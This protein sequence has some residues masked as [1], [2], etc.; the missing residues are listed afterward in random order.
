[1]TTRR[2][3]DEALEDVKAHRLPGGV[4]RGQRRPL[5]RR[6]LRAGGDARSATGRRSRRSDRDRGAPRSRSPTAASR[7]AS[8][9]RA[10]RRTGTATG[11][12]WRRSSRR[13]RRSGCADRARH[14]TEHALDQVVETGE[15]EFVHD[16]STVVPARGHARVARLPARR[17]GSGSPTPSTASPRTRPA[18]RS[19]TRRRRRT[20]RCC[21]RIEEELHDRIVS[22]R[23]DALTAIAHHEVDGERLPE[24]I[25]QSIAF[26]TTVGGIDTTTALAGGALLHLSAVPRRPAAADRRA[27]RCSRSPPRSSSASI[28]RRAPTSASSPPTP[29]S[30]ASQMKPGDEVLLSEVAAGRDESEFPDADTFVDRPQPEPA[31]VVRRRHPPLPG[32]APRAHHVLGDDLGGARAHARLPHRPRRRSIDYPDWAMVGGWQRMPGD[33]HADHTLRS[34]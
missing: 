11:A 27:R 21:A 19:T 8:P 15:I 32:L 33:V 20:S 5:D 2:A 12:R 29:S 10:T 23:D 26:L 13:R 1:M 16:L 24:D 28:R 7:R 25:A 6:Q 18:R 17:S 9:R 14:W 31:R 3:S 34:R 22:P 30:V 4:D